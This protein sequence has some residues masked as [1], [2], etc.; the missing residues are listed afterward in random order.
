MIIIEFTEIPQ[1]TI[2]TSAENGTIDEAVQV[3]R[4]KRDGPF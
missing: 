3:R 4:E 1:Y 2:E